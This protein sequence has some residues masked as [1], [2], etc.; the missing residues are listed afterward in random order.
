MLVLIAYAWIHHL[1]VATVR[2]SK[3][4]TKLELEDLNLFWEREGFTGLGIRSVLVVQSEQQIDGRRVGCARRPKL[5]WKKL[6]EKD[7]HE[8]K[9]TTVDPQERSTWR[10]GVSS[11][12]RA[13]SQLPER[14]STDVEDALHLHFNQISVYDD[15]IMKSAWTAI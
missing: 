13:A 11:A 3:I 7:C 12:I 14:G 5:A 4:P 9:L 6:A 2:S 1:R 8:W 10:S 15:D